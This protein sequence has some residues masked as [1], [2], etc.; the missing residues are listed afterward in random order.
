MHSYFRKKKTWQLQI[1]GNIDC[2]T[3]LDFTSVKN[4][5]KYASKWMKY[6]EEFV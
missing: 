6:Y 5:K 4:V 2:K 3:Y 1:K